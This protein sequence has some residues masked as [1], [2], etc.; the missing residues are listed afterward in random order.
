M[1][2]KEIDLVTEELEGEFHDLVD[3]DTLPAVSQGMLTAS[4]RTQYRLYRSGRTQVRE[5]LKRHS[6]RRSR[7]FTRMFALGVTPRSIGPSIVV[8]STRPPVRV[9]PTV[10]GASDRPAPATV[11]S[12]IAGTVSPSSAMQVNVQKSTA[13]T[14]SRRWV[15]V[16]GTS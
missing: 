5:S 16:S 9:R 11:G 4:I 12:S 2:A 3:S 6:L 10:A 8:H 1:R 7:E 15:S 14:L 13:T